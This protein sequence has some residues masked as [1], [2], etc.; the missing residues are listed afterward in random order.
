MMAEPRR[1]GRVG[2]GVIVLAGVAGLALA[3]CE[4]TGGGTA[5]PGVG[6]VGGAAAGAGA[7]RLLFG[8]ST[9]GMLIGGA[10]GGLAGNM[11]LD[12][13]TEQRRQQEAGSA[14]QT[15]NQVQLD[16]ERQRAL[17]G[18]QTRIEIEEQRLFQQWQRE[19]GGSA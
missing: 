4:T 13:Q 12:R 8:N 9:T 19:R 10:A 5:S 18:E 17:L 1:S 15:K 11:M 2:L 7:G 16:F 6:T 3:G 14:R